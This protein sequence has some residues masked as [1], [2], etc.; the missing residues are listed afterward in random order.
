MTVC[1]ETDRGPWVQALIAAG[2]RVHAANPRQAARFKER[3]GTSGAKSDKGGAHALA[4]MVRIDG[5]RPAG[6]WCPRSLPH[7]WRWRGPPW[8]TTSGTRRSET[9]GPG[10]PD[11]P[12]RIAVSRIIAWCRTTAV[13]AGTATAALDSSCAARTPASLVTCA[14]NRPPP[15]ARR[16]AAHRAPTRPAG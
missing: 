8:S 3:Y 1:I 6:G 11:A 12:A 2:C 13:A 9:P 14:I 16:A 10:R 5:A 7:R 15:R 4:D